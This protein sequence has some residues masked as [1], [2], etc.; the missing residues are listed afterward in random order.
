MARLAHGRPLTE[1]D[2]NTARDDIVAFSARSTAAFALV[3]A[4]PP[5]PF[6]LLFPSL[7]DNPANLVEQTPE[8]TRN[9]AALGTAMADPDVRGQ[10]SPIPAAYTYFG[11]FVDHDITLE[12][13]NPGSGAAAD[14]VDENM[15]PMPLAD[16]RTALRNGRTATLDLDSVYE[17]PA[18]RD[19]ANQDKMQIGSNTDVVS[20]STPFQQVPGKDNQ[21]DLPRLG[22]S[23]RPEL[24]RA[25]L[26]GD[27]RNDEN[28]I[29]SQLHLAFLKAHNVLVKQGLPFE[30]ARR[31]L[32]QH[33]QHIV[34]HD[35]LRRVCDPAV[36]DDL[37]KNGNRWFDPYGASFYMP[38]EFSVAAYRFGHSMVRAG[39]N[40]NVNF[41]FGAANSGPATLEDLFTFTA[42]SGELRNLPTLPNNWIIEWENIVGDDAQKARKIDTT[43]AKVGDS[44]LFNLQTLEGE[45]EKPDL[46][47]R[48]AVR[49]LLRGYR[50]R[51]PTGQA[52]AQLLGEPVLTPQQLLAATG[53]ENGDQAR[54][55]RQGSLLTRTPLWYYIL[56]E[57]Q[58]AHQGARLG[59][60]GSTMVAEV[61]I[62]LIRRS[63]DSILKVPGWRPSLPAAKPGT[64]ELADLLRLAGV[65]GGPAAPPK[66]RTYTVRSG[67]TLTGIAE[68]EL[69]DE[70]RWTQIYVLNRKDIRDPNRIFVGQVFVLPE[71]E[72]VGPIP[73]LHVVKRGDTLSAIAQAHLGDA[74]RWPEIFRLNRDVLDNPDRI[75]PGQVL[76]LPS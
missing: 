42:F 5:G 43:L 1:V 4:P 36:V 49:N 18:P 24:D 73:R 6:D 56:A 15:V 55:L 65:L 40:F 53:D 8:T 17:P 3:G 63:A 74:N 41:R 72:P 19:P 70:R 62:G 57:A 58:V 44:A 27:G 47:A 60:V 11:Q 21:N 31:T 71:Q 50:L 10:D 16:V 13:Q 29:I 7:Q 9:L 68:R 22:P 52:V 69:G 67:D 33:Y 35:F 14:L 34:V 48:L 61:L 26:I 59:R 37:V 51:L 38:L 66:P 30:T 46:A 54:A 23:P 76:I 20:G 45:R 25:A 28:T 12:I 64:Y 39:Y 32:R 75:I 2:L